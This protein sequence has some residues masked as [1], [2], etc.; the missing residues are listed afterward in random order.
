MPLR[1]GQYTT[2]GSDKVRALVELPDG[3]IMI[4]TDGGGITEYN[5][6]AAPEANQWRTFGLADGV[7]DSILDLAVDKHDRLWAATDRGVFYLTGHGW[8]RFHP[9][10]ANDTHAATSIAF[11]EDCRECFT[12]SDTIVIG[13]AQHGII[14]GIVPPK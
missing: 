13:T 12:N 10:R 6:N 11:G 14:V 8:Q 7:A 3:R 9:Q 1:D 5:P 2:L 4:G